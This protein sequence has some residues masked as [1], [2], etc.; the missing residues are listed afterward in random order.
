MPTLAELLAG[1]AGQVQYP[2][3]EQ[4]LE[5]PPKHKREIINAVKH[6]KA[7]NWKAAKGAS[8]REKFEAIKDI[9]NNIAFAYG[10]QVNV[11]FVPDT[12]IGCHL[13]PQTNTITIDDNLSIISALH[14]LANHL[15]GKSEIKA[16]RWSIWLFKKTFPKEYSRLIWQDHMLV[17]PT[18]PTQKIAAPGDSMISSE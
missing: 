15:F 6:W 13:N 7:E 3:K 2:T 18:C 14:E 16:C 8:P 5:R 9:I 17:K 10:K 11:E 12:P 1:V 4:I